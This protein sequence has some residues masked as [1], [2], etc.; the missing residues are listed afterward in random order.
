MFLVREVSSALEAASWA[1]GCKS[2]QQ[3]YECVLQ[4]RC[5]MI[6]L[7]R[8]LLLPLG[9]VGDVRVY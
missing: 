6:D 9:H 8:N 7:D 4:N 1:R 5:C 3:V 2:F